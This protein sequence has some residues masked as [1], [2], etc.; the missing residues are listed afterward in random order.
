MT[1]EKITVV[2]SIEVKENGCVQV[3]AATRVV[4]NGN[5]LSQSFHRHV[6]APGDDYSSEDSRV[7]TICAVVHTKQAVDSYKTAQSNQ[8]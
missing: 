5:I 7:R 8:P 1:L 2:D 3:R 6:V 4:E